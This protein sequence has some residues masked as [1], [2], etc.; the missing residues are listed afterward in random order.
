[1][2]SASSLGVPRIVGYSFLIMVLLN[3]TDILL[4]PRFLNPTWE[5]ETVGAIVES[6]P[7]LLFAAV[8]F[9]Y[10]ENEYRNRLEQILV[11]VLSQICLP[12]AI[13]FFLLVPMSANSTIRINQ[14]IDSQ[15]GDSFGF[16]MAQVDELEQQLEQASNEEIIA[17]LKSQGVQG[18]V[19]D[20][21]I[22]PKELLL[23]YLTETRQ[24]IRRETNAAKRRR[25]RSTTKNAMKW[26]IGA[27]IS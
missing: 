9:F 17:I 13:C 19:E 14:E 24:E 7:L 18:V 22:V 2:R 20:Q 5:L 27:I 3:W 21:S 26:T 12:V 6:T 23:D 16:Q 1:M 4:P 10:G 25:K 15:V 11:R 8:L